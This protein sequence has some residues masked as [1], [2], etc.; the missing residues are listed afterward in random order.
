MEKEIMETPM[1]LRRFFDRQWASLGQI[2]EAIRDFKPQFVVL[3]ARGTSD[4][5]C[6]YARYLIEKEWG[7]P[8]SL[9]APSIMTL[10]GGKISF[11]RAVVMGVSQSGEGPD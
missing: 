5:A 10:Y 7:I 2:E 6:S 8:V 4:N 11:G 9:A 3:V 1:A